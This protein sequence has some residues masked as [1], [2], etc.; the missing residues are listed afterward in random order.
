MKL[1]LES[2]FRNSEKRPLNS[3]IEIAI[4]GLQT[5]LRIVKEAAGNSGVP[6]LQAGIGSILFVID[7]VKVNQMQYQL[8]QES[9]CLL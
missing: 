7:V 1:K 5:I 6:G 2:R 8:F 3:A 4:S 9:R